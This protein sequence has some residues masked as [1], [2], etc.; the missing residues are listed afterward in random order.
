M[1]A[2]MCDGSWSRAQ[3]VNSSGVKRLRMTGWVKAPSAE[4]SG[5]KIGLLTAQP[6]RAGCMCLRAC[7]RACLYVCV[8]VCVSH[9]LIETA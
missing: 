3:D 8:C 9:T 1:T 5:F 2:V 7:L 4:A 6:C